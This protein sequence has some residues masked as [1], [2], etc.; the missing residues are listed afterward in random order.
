M[1]WRNELE[2]SL[3]GHREAILRFTQDLV[4]IPSENPPGNAYR[5]CL[6][7]VGRELD[8]LEIP[9]RIV[10]TPGFPDHPRANLLAF[11]GEGGPVLYFHGHYDVVPAQRPEQFQPQV[12]E[13]ALYGRGSADMKSGLAA[14]IYAAHLLG[15]SGAPLKGRI[16]L[17]VVAD[18]ETGGQGGSRHLQEIGLLGRDAVAML[19]PE[20]TSGVVWNA[21]RG[22]VTLRVTVRG[23]P[24]H[25]GLQHQGVNAFERMLDVAGALRELKAEVELRRTTYKVVP[26]EAA[27]SILMLGG[28]V[29]G[30]TNFN[31][32]PERCSFTLERRFNPEEDFDTE[33]A[34]LTAVLDRMRE[35]GIDLE[36]EMLQECRSSGV[37]PDQPA[38]VALAETIES[39]TG[40]RPEFELCPGSLEIRW[41]AQQGIPAFAYGPGLL[42][43]AH[44]PEEW[45]EIEQVYRHT[46]IYALYA[47][48][49]LG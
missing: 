1:D 2:R 45:V 13:G 40:R 37:S 25:V 14:M 5:E 34:R 20:P 4:R 30:G 3:A 12:R 7:R 18:E 35:R 32:V 24:A 26:E 17:C 16:G 36:V 15:R 47:A 39:V 29:E 22:A 41:Y 49:M 33:K 28:R 23:R 42:E 19:T 10:E 27:H 38:A 21:N 6:Q 48:R 44:G 8:R 31:V 11:V 46:L 43:V 9:Y